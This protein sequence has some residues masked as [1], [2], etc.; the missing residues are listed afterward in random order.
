[1]RQ[2][3]GVIKYLCVLVLGTHRKGMTTTRERERDATPSSLSRGGKDY[4]L[5]V[6]ERMAGFDDGDG[7]RG[8]G[9]GGAPRVVLMGPRRGGE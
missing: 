3:L 9:G 2:R 4:R 7:G 8:G 1:M 6:S 5:L